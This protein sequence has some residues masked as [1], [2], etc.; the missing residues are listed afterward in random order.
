MK[1]L[2]DT[3]II[4]ITFCYRK[5]WLRWVWERSLK[6]CENDEMKKNQ[7][8][9]GF[10]DKVSSLRSTITWQ[11]GNQI[12][13]CA[14]SCCK[15]I[16]RFKNFSIL[17]SSISSIKDWMVFCNISRITSSDKFLSRTSS[18]WCDFPKYRPNHLFFEGVVYD[19][20]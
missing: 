20:H 13:I 14:S 2:I 11:A 3:S 4:S 1:I 16:S 6:I 15:T 8:S 9:R 19:L 10:P 18:Q 5:L 7:W 17:L 12:S